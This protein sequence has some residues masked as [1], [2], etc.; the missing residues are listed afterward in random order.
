MSSLHNGVR[1]RMKCNNKYLW[2]P[3]FS[4]RCQ[5][6]SCATELKLSGPLSQA[7][8]YNHFNVFT[9]TP[10]SSEG[11]VGEI[12]EPSNKTVLDH[13]NLSLLPWLSLFSHSLAFPSYLSLLRCL[14]CIWWSTFRGNYCFHLQ[15]EAINLIPIYQTL[16]HHVQEHRSPGALILQY[17]NCCNLI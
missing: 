2:D 3:Q 14:V 1:L 5:M 13:N 9:L 12:W 7:T 10:P 6:I 11:R 15:V 8:V 4:Q 17:R 16:R